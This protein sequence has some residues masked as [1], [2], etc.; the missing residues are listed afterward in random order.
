MAERHPEKERAADDWYVEPAWCVDILL[1]RV[2]FPMGLHDPCCGGG[3]IPFRARE[4]GFTATGSDLRE[5][6]PGWRVLNFL[7]DEDTYSSIVTN[8]PYNIAVPIIEH[9][10]RHVQQGGFVCALV[11]AKFLFSQKRKELFERVDMERVIILSRRPSMP[12]GEALSEHG[13]SIRGGGSIDFCWV[14]WRVGKGEPG[15]LIEWAI[16]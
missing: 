5:R 16:Q 4:L 8:P 15:A 10:L 6:A 7:R 14:V 12:P 9:A 1:K 3:T 11:Q 2:Q 13:E